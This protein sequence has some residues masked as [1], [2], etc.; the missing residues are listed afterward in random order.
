M[1]LRF[2]NYAQRI[3]FPVDPNLSHSGSTRGA[4]V[5]W[6]RNKMKRH[7]VLLDLILF[8]AESFASHISIIILLYRFMYLLKKLKEC[9]TPVWVQG[10][11]ER[12]QV[13]E[14]SIHSR[15]SR[16]LE[17]FFVSLVIQLKIVCTTRRHIGTKL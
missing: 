5:I 9:I 7:A 17:V 14:F 6:D 15:L 13:Y 16:C 3:F 2:G 8:Y 11:S 10:H 4:R 12:V 1:Q